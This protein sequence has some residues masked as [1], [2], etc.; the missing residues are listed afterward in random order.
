M[1]GT[2]NDKNIEKLLAILPKNAIYYFCEANIPRAMP[3]EILF[4]LAKQ[5]KLKGQE[6]SSVKAALSSA[7]N[8]ANNKDLIFVGGSTFVVAEAL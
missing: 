3:K 1:L 8:N 6:Y 5:Y 2:V 7:Q 4:T